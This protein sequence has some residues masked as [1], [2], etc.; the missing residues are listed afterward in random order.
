MR[1]QE[2]KKKSRII[3]FLTCFEGPAG[4]KN[5]DSR[6]VTEIEIMLSLICFGGLAGRVRQRLFT[7]EATGFYIKTNSTVEFEDCF[8]FFQTQSL[9]KN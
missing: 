2:I 3:L 7:K 8:A 9:Y 4:F 5:A 1:T 6:D